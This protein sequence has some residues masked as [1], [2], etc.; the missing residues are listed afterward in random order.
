[1]PPELSKPNITRA[2]KEDTME[3]QMM[4]VVIGKG[5]D[6]KQLD[7]DL[8]AIDAGTYLGRITID[9]SVADEWDNKE[10]GAFVD[11]LTDEEVIDGAC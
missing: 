4:E 11:G 5:I 6:L 9:E 2:Q 8:A 10:L 7:M 3:E 1:M